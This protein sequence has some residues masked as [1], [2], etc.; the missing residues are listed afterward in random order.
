MC[1]GITTTPPTA[2]FLLSL[3]YSLKIDCNLGFKSIRTLLMCTSSISFSKKFF[4]DDINVQERPAQH[5]KVTYSQEIS[6]LL[7][8]WFFSK[9]R[10][11]K[12]ESVETRLW[13]WDSSSVFS[14]SS[15]YYSSSHLVVPNWVK[16]LFK[17]RRIRTSSFLLLFSYWGPLF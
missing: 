14:S 8:A 3:S 2:I 13:N 1:W 12:R 9:K 7:S 10:R 5:L 11:Y 4:N 17:N 15:I 6:L 16:Q